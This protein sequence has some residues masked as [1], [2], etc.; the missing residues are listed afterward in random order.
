[1][2]L[3]ENTN[4]NHVIGRGWLPELR[5]PTCGD[6]KNL[7]SVSGT[8]KIKCRSCGSERKREHRFVMDW[9][10]ILSGPLPEQCPACANFWK[11]VLEAVVLK[12]DEGTRCY[13][14]YLCSRCGAQRYYESTSHSTVE[15]IPQ[16]ILISDV[17]LQ[18]FT[19]EIEEF[20]EIE[21][22][23][24]KQHAAVR[25]RTKGRRQ[26]SNSKF[27]LYGDCASLRMYGK[28]QYANGRCRHCGI[29]REVKTY[30][31]F[32]SAVRN[33]IDAMPDYAEP[34]ESWGEEY[35][36]GR[37]ITKPARNKLAQF[38]TAGRQRTAHKTRRSL[39]KRHTKQD[40]WC[41]DAHFVFRGHGLSMTP[42]ATWLTKS[43]KRL[44]SRVSLVL[45]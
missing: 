25:F 33:M 16:Q 22:I 24:R 5:C 42:R 4:N 9:R 41:A 23:T 1:M 13:R 29:K 20:K 45:R 3:I 26:H 10:P 43:W 14:L 8:E 19:L 28:H 36:L 44:P 17:E 27:D 12:R 7:E 2:G 39:G 32:L 35:F 11:T 38:T 30:R 15:P 40:Y 21:V 34:W 6:G 31:T 18:S 37:M